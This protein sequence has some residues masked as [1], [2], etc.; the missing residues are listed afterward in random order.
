MAMTERRYL[1]LDIET[2]PLEITDESVWVYLSEKATRRELHPVFSK[3]LA[4]GIKQPNKQPEVIHDDNERTILEKFW[5]FIGELKPDTI[6]TFNGYGFDI[7]FIYARSFINKTKPTIKIA[8][9]KWHMETSNHFD[10]M[11]AFSQYGAF[12][13][14]AQAIICKMLGIDVPS[15]IISG[16]QIEDCYKRRD[17]KP[18]I[19]R[20]EQDLIMTEKLYKKIV[21]T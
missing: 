6:V 7:P 8:T 12:I 14:V 16:S 11:I 3:I 4:I 18:I 15:D 9:N 5:G 21:R 10:C 20:C 13:N 1:V 2:I 19:Y 17:W